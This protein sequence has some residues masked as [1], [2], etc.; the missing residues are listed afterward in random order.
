MTTR[1][2]SSLSRHKKGTADI[3]VYTDIIRVRTYKGLEYTVKTPWWLKRALLQH[4][5]YAE[6]D[7]VYEIKRALGF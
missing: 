3:D 5:K 1:T 2:I 4:R 7:K 6:A